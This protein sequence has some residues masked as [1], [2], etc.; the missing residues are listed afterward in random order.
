[1]A[2]TTILVSF[3][4]IAALGQEAV[5]P[6]PTVTVGDWE[7]VPVGVTEGGVGGLEKVVHSFLL[8]RATAALYYVRNDERVHVELP[9]TASSALRSRRVRFVPIGITEG[10]LGGGK[11]VAHA[12]IVDNETGDCWYVKNDTA[13]PVRTEGEQREKKAK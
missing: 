5:P 9:G 8:D 3:A 7:L 12:Y 2:L 4:F 11:K 10:G 1:M 13:V 6:A